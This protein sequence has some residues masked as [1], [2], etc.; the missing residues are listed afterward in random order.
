MRS[1]ACSKIRIS[2]RIIIPIKVITPMM[3][4]RP[5]VRFIKAKPINTPGNISP[6]AAIQT[7][8]MPY[9]LKLKS[10]KKKMMTMA[11]ATPPKICGRASASYSISPPTSART[12]CG[13]GISFF[14]ISAILLST[15]AA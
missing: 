13:N 11:M 7:I 4:V 12:P 3:D 9:F 14:M 2:L 15:G 8:L 5:R 1:R 6:R 10:R